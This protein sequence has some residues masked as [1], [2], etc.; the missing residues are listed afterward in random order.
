MK[1]IRNIWISGM[2]LVKKVENTPNKN[3]C[4]QYVK[5]FY[6]DG[7]IRIE[8]RFSHPRYPDYSKTVNWYKG[9][10]EEAKAYS[11]MLRWD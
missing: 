9:S 10:L 11:R 7:F 4:T 5:V 2:E 3:W 8:R 1:S 6:K